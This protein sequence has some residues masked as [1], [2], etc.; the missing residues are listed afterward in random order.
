MQGRSAARISDPNRI[1]TGIRTFSVAGSQ[2]SIRPLTDFESR[3]PFTYRIQSSKI[4][5]FLIA[6]CSNGH[7]TYRFG[8]RCASF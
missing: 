6:D 5:R 2:Y 4:M 3:L 1:S 8:C 7:N